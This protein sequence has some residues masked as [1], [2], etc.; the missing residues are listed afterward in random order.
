[1]AYANAALAYANVFTGNWLQ[2]KTDIFEFLRVR[3]RQRVDSSWMVSAVSFAPVPHAVDSDSIFGLIEQHAVV[4][5]AQPQQSLELAAQRLDSSGAG[6]RV[7]VNRRQNVQGSLL[8]NGADFL[9]NVR[10]EADFLHGSLFACAAPNLIHAE[11]A[12]GRH[13]FQGE[14]AFRILPEIFP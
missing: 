5:H 7:S 11:A 13:L 1:M 3:R 10:V 8:L 2:R 9:P 12:V 6:R 4:A 14:A